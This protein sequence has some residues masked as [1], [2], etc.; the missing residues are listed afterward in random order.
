MTNTSL[1]ENSFQ[2]MQINTYSNNYNYNQIVSNLTYID[3]QDIKWNILQSSDNA[4]YRNINDI[5][6]PIPDRYLNSYAFNDEAAR[7]YSLGMNPFTVELY[8]PTCGCN[9]CS[10]YLKLSLTNINCYIS[11]KDLLFAIYNEYLERKIDMSELCKNDIDFVIKN[12]LNRLNDNEYVKLSSIMKDLILF[13]N[14][15]K[16]D[17]KY[18]LTLKNFN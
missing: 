13:D 16:Y 5:F 2:N 18:Y 1:L 11:V 9:H 4:L 10:S 14:I 17:G 7:C 15:S 3:W 6:E 12:A 8:L